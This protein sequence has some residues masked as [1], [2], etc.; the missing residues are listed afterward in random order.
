MGWQVTGNSGGASPGETAIPF[1]T[2]PLAYS[3]LSNF[4]SGMRSPGFLDHGLCRKRNTGLGIGSWKLAGISNL[5][6][7]G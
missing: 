1:C 3:R 5:C 4:A 2:R 7:P 6:D